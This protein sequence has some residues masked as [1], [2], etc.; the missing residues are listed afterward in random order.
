MHTE[1]M[2]VLAAQP[3][4]PV[5]IPKPFV[6]AAVPEIYGR[7]NSTSNRTVNWTNVSADARIKIRWLYVSESTQAICI[8]IYHRPFVVSSGLIFLR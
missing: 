2:P 1:E 8:K 5:M 6:P 7:S 3:A 4:R